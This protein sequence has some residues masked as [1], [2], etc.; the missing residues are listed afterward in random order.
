MSITLSDQLA[1]RL[2]WIVSIAVFAVVVILSNLPKANTVP[3]IVTY[4][5]KLNAICNATAFILLIF[6]LQSIKSGKVERH[7]KLNLAAFVVSAIFLLSYVAFHSFGVETHFPVENAL[8]STYL[9][10]LIT[11]IIL[12]A[13]VLPLVLF[14]FYLG[15]TGKIDK[16]RKLSKFTYPIWLYVTLSGVIV[17][18][19]ISPYYKF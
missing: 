4:L 13:V 9:F 7:K 18:L 6:S 3:E 1:K 11:H 14:S 15:L 17:Y 16:H 10:I 19:M 12:A 8:R 2:I 5:P